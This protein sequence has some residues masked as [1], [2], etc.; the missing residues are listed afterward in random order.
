MI[1]IDFKSTC[2]YLIFAICCLFWNEHRS[3]GNLHQAFFH[4]LLLHR[5][6]FHYLLPFPCCHHVIYL[7]LWSSSPCVISLL[8]NSFDLLVPEKRLSYYTVKRFLNVCSIQRQCQFLTSCSIR[9][10]SLS[11][12]STAVILSYHFSPAFL[13][14]KAM[15]LICCIHCFIM[16]EILAVTTNKWNN[17]YGLG[18]HCWLYN[19][20]IVFYCLGCSTPASL[21][22]FY[23]MHGNFAVLPVLN[24]FPTR[25][26]P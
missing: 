8:S 6:F 16:K 24:I 13:I 14:H 1:I 23:N 25:R 22:A 9:I 15:L 2:V 26:A 3:S 10:L 18:I 21:L 4:Y 12:S 5:A 17:D 20:A 19:S 7:Y 11:I